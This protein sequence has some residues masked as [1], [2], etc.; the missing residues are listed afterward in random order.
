MRHQQTSMPSDE[1]ICIA[2]LL[3]LDIREILKTKSQS[4]IEQH[5]KRMVQ[6]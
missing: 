2:A 4:E 3:N 6:L 1:A 5:E